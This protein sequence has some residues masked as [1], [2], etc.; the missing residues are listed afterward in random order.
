M[1]TPACLTS[2]LFDEG[3]APGSIDYTT[4]G[5]YSFTVPAGV[6]EIQ[7]VVTAGGAGGGG[8]SGQ[9]NGNSA[10]YPG[11]GGGGGGSLNG[12]L[13]EG[14]YP[15]AVLT[16][17][18]G[19]GGIKGVASGLGPFGDRG[20]GSPGGNGEDSTFGSITVTGG[21]GSQGSWNGTNGSGSTSPG[22]LGGTPNGGNG[23]PAT[24]TAYGTGGVG[25]TCPDAPYGKGGKGGNGVSGNQAAGAVSIEAGSDGRVSLTW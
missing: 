2:L 14:V 13:T 25:G 23:G 3:Y 8:Q 18:V 7:Y 17:K 4:P 24:G 20:R 9:G 16:V 15:G 11:T 12:V 10:V 6:Y 22:G 19:G 5:T 1:T 21:K